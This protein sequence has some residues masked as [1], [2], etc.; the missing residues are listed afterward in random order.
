MLRN[1]FIALI[2]TVI[3]AGCLKND[4]QPSCPYTPLSSKVPTAELN[5]L[6]TYLDTNGIDAQMHPAGFYYKITT[7]GAGTDSMG[8]CSVIDINYQLRLTN[9]SLVESQIGTPRQFF[10][11]GLIEG[12]QKGIPLVK[13]GGEIKLYIPPKLGMVQHRLKN[14]VMYLVQIA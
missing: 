1:L 13:K 11:G 7:A 5:A 6:E 8:L 3:A 4:S 14:Q 2:I 12:F 9:D 10:L